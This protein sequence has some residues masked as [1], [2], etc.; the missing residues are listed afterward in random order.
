MRE[1]RKGKFEFSKI[2]KG[3]RERL[4]GIFSFLHMNDDK[5][6]SVIYF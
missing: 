2:G 6:S 5:L 3:N 1:V 4:K